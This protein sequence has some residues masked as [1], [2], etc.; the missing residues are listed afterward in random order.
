M[1]IMNDRI[2][3]LYNKLGQLYVV[4]ERITEDVGIIKNNLDK[5]NKSKGL[6]GLKAVA[7]ST[8]LKDFKPIEGIGTGTKKYKLFFRFIKE[9]WKSTVN[10]FLIGV[11]QQD[12][13]SNYDLKALGIRIHVHDTKKLRQLTKQVISLLHIS[14]EINNIDSTTILREIIQEINAGSDAMVRDVKGQIHHQK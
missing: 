3:D 9:E 5:Y 10:D 14:C 8:P 4:M 2:D 6:F 11:K 7:K 12:R 13:T 1:D